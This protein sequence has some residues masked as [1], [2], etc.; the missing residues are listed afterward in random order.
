MKETHR[1]K[2]CRGEP[3]DRGSLK[4]TLVL[5][6][7]RASHSGKASSAARTWNVVL[8]LLMVGGNPVNS[9][10]EVGS[11]NPIIYRISYMPGGCLGFLNHQQYFFIWLQWLIG[12][13]GRRWYAHWVSYKSVSTNHYLVAYY[14]RNT[15]WKANR[16]K[17]P[18]LINYQPT[19]T[20]K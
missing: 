12:G 19:S 1:N 6:V 18:M 20:T 4:E 13:D 17:I 2:M 9:P 3:T 8:M 5:N 10:V 16:L 11:W 7:K 15:L 14:P